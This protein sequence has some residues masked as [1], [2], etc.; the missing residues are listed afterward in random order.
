VNDSE[1]RSYLLGQ[2][3]AADAERLE[4]RLL[5]DEEAFATLQSVEDDLFDDYA[6]DRLSPVERGR[7]VER[8]GRRTDRLTFARALARRT[9]GAKVVPI[10]RQPWVPMAAAA[11]VVIAVAGTVT[12]Q[13][14]AAGP[15][16]AVPVAAV[17]ERVETAAP[18]VELALGASRAAGGSS[19]VTLA[20]DASALPVRVRLHPADRYDRY[21]MELRSSSGQV[22]WRGEA[23][24]A[25]SG[26]ELALL[27]AVPANLLTSGSYELAVHGTNG[28]TPPEDLGFLTLKVRRT[29]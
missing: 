14:P 22:V 15:A 7:F 8:F 11:A 10:R 29:Q 21:S 20:K 24:P 16:P 12:R 1:L 4:E 28:E 13:R 3:P 5:E 18:A 25:A 2:L 23:L 27:A 6:R 17:P 26:R 19:V 9:A